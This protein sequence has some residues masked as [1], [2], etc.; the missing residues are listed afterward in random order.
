MSEYNF[1]AIE[2]KW[3]TIWAQKGVFRASDSSPKPKYYA[4]I[5]IPYT[6]GEGLHVGHPRSY[7]ALAI[8]ILPGHSGLPFRSS[9]AAQK[10]SVP[11]HAKIAPPL[12]SLAI[13]ALGQDPPSL[14]PASE[15][16]AA[17]LLHSSFP[18]GPKL[19]A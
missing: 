17:L 13:K 8:W 19:W 1:K 9:L 10:P 14:L 7:T 6:S 11:T 3:Q 5:E 4:L 12:T 18:W 15:W 16:S 2:Q